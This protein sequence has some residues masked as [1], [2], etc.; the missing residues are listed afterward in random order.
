MDGTYEYKPQNLKD[1]A[2]DL[3]RFQLGD[4]EVEGG[5]DTCALCDEEYDAILEMYPDNWDRA[6]LACIESI[7]RRFSYEPDTTDGP[8]SLKFGDRAKLWQDEYKRLK[9]ELEA[10]DLDPLAI[11]ANLCQIHRDPYFRLG[12]MS[13]DHVGETK[14][15]RHHAR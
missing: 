12:M 7:F 11:D 2:K 10:K 5:A 15:V 13:R 8:V 14:E 1:K 9:E 3:M 4:T 6:K